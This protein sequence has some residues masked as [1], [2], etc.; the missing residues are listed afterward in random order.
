[1]ITDELIE[2]ITKI[3]ENFKKI[4]LNT[5]TELIEFA[6]FFKDLSSL[7]DKNIVKLENFKE[8]D[9][10]NDIKNYSGDILDKE[11]SKLKSVKSIILS[12]CN[13][14]FHCNV[15]EMIYKVKTSKN[16]EES[17]KF[18]QEHLCILSNKIIDYLNTCYLEHNIKMAR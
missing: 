5:H 4:S 8:E 2:N 15:D 9:I 7:C 10:K 17:F 1:M 6:I 18:Y 12:Y 14:N 3:L 11:I 13:F 16:S